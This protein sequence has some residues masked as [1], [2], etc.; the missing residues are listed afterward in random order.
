MHMYRINNFDVPYI[1]IHP[2]IPILHFS[3]R[4]LTIHLTGEWSEKRIVVM[5][6]QIP[7]ASLIMNVNLCRSIILLF[8]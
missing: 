2:N 7:C 6:D 8:N 1:Y 5:T 4:S 3:A